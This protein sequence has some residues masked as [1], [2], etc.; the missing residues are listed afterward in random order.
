M[1]LEGE[2][3]DRYYLIVNGEVEV[4]IEGEFVRHMP[5][6]R[7]FG[8]VALL[9]DIPRTATVTRATPVE[10]LVVER[11]EFLGALSGH[12]RTM[13]AASNAASGFMAD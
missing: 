7:S 3:G 11:A 9:R 10:L 12:P 6:G 5:A 4:T 8:E 1:I 2:V 13:A